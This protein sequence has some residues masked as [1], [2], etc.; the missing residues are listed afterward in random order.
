MQGPYP[1]GEDARDL[2]RLGIKD[3][4]ILQTKRRSYPLPAH[5]VAPMNRGKPQGAGKLPPASAGYQLQWVN[6]GRDRKWK[7]A[8]GE[9][10]E[11]ELDEEPKR[12]WEKAGLAWMK[13]D[14]QRAPV[15]DGISAEEEG[16]D[17]KR[18]W[19]KSLLTRWAQD[20]CRW[21]NNCVEELSVECGGGC[22]R[23]GE[24]SGMS[25]MKRRDDDD[26]KRR[27]EKSGMSWMKRRRGYD[28]DDDHSYG[29]YDQAAAEEPA[30]NT[31]RRWEKSGVSWIRRRK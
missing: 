2:E 19:E 5:G 14:N 24:K 13:K 3:H 27:W 15:Y 1:D 23:R 12:R 17:T 4:S 31:K 10:D 22:V 6:G 9:P 20:S 8:N 11:I 18:R 7:E 26:G 25:W 30:E 29:D 21:K 28:D 16:G